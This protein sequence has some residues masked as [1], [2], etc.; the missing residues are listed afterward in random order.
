MLRCFQNVRSGGVFG[1]ADRTLLADNGR[2]LPTQSGLSAV[3]SLLFSVRKRE[4]KTCPFTELAFH[5]NR[6]AMRFYKSFT[7]GEP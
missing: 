3:R 1:A 4:I 5:H 6:S 7:D 2:L